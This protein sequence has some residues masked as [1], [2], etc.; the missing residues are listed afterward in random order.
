MSSAELGRSP[1]PRVRLWLFVIVS[2]IVGWLLLAG[3]GFNELY[4][5]KATFGANMFGD[6]LAL[7]AWGFGAEASRDAITALVRGWGLP[8]GG[9]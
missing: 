4:M 5:Q 1:W 2:F 9:E 3:A 8:V 6:Y 7:F